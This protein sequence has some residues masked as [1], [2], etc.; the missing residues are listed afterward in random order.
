MA[1]IIVDRARKTRMSFEKRRT[2]VGEEMT[3]FL[4]QK[5]K[6]TG[7]A[8]IQRIARLRKES[9]REFEKA[10]QAS[11]K[12]QPTPDGALALVMYH[13]AEAKIEEELWKLSAQ[14][15]ATLKGV[16]ARERR[17]ARVRKIKRIIA[18]VR[19]K[20]NRHGRSITFHNKRMNIAGKMAIELSKKP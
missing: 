18:Q 20:R 12:D 8:I 2:L 15:I 6:S 13:K 3:K 19:N 7:S 9:A 14:R 10:H 4:S 11:E 5:R 17:P 1:K 16:L